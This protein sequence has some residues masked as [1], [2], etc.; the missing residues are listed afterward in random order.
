MLDQEGERRVRYAEQENVGSQNQMSQPD[1]DVAPHERRPI[2]RGMSN[3]HSS[4]YAVNGVESNYDVDKTEDIPQRSKAKPPADFGHPRG[5]AEDPVREGCYSNFGKGG[6]RHYR[7]RQVGPSASQGNNLKFKEG[8]L[9]PDA[10]DIRYGHQCTG[11]GTKSPEGPNQRRVPYLAQRQENFRGCGPLPPE[12]VSVKIPPQYSKHAPFADHFK[13]TEYSVTT[14]NQV[15][16]VGGERKHVEPEDPNKNPKDTSHL[17]RR[18]E[19]PP[20]PPGIE[21]EYRRSLAMGEYS[22]QLSPRDRSK[23]PAWGWNPKPRGA[24]DPIPDVIGTHANHTAGQKHRKRTVDPR[25][26]E[27]NF[28]GASTTRIRD[29]VPSK[30]MIEP[31]WKVKNTFATVGVTPRD[32]NPNMG[33]EPEDPRYR[34]EDARRS[35]PKPAHFAGA[36]SDPNYQINCKKLYPP[37]RDAHHR[38]TF[39][40]VGVTPEAMGVPPELQAGGLKLPKPP[41]PVDRGAGA[42]SEMM[43]GHR[44][45]KRVTQ[46]GINERTKNTF[47]SVGSAMT[48]MDDRGRPMGEPVPDPRTRKIYDPF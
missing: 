45:G 25:F 41:V 26:Q 37:Q 10:G 6:V 18:P 22:G 44:V 35:K 8:G 36:I 13:D 12:P 33:L 23:D 3:A 42:S 11:M 4:K 27:G 40:T 43:A 20:P 1:P 9:E 15:F 30:A 7:K 48:F 19:S 46:Q 24:D 47:E 16:G 38:D 39:D 14:H 17:F 34:F 31:E 29:R 5:F 2:Q 21:Q 28:A 32:L